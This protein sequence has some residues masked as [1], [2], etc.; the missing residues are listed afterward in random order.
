MFLYW[1]LI[2]SWLLSCWRFFVRYF[3]FFL[4]RMQRIIKNKTLFFE[5]YCF[6]EFNRKILAGNFWTDPMCW[7]I[8]W[9]PL[10]FQFR[11]I[12]VVQF[13]FS[14]FCTSLW[15]YLFCW[16]YQ[17]QSPGVFCKKSVFKK[18]SKNYASACNFIE[19]LL[20]HRCFPLNFVK[21]WRTCFLQNTLGLLFLYIAVEKLWFWFEC[22]CK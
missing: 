20:R 15:I 21:I 17:G 19:K 6:C 16:N 5:D 1:F 11:K 12:C 14:P 13:L 18:F 10:E 3:F 4:E 9:I 2:F 22:S 8:I 7:F